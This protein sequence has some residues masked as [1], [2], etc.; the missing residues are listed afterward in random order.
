M[1]EAIGYKNMVGDTRVNKFND[2]QVQYD[3]EWLKE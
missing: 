1:N 3:S 2:N